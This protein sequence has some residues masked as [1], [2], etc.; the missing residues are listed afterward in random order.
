MRISK[1]LLGGL[2]VAFLTTSCHSEPKDDPGSTT[3]EGQDSA[4]MT[5][6]N[7]TLADE[8]WTK[9]QLAGTRFL[10]SGGDALSV[11]TTENAF[12]VFM[13]KNG[14]NKTEGI[15]GTELK[16]SVQVSQLAL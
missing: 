15:F 9:V 8:T 2:I 6:L 7:A 14:G 11:Y 16:S 10:W 13:L 4:V 12:K 3:P 1:L 5:V